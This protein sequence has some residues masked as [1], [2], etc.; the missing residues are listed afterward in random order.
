MI[1]ALKI[2][3]Y[4]INE[5]KK[6][7]FLYREDSSASITPPSTPSSVPS[8]PRGTSPKRTCVCCGWTVW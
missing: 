1:Y 3:T 6:K 5:T 8:T 2:M 7:Q 4:N